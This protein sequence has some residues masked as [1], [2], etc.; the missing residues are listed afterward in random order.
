[1][2]TLRTRRPGEFCWINMLTPEPEQARGFFGS[3]LG[4]TYSDMPGMGHLIQ[5]GG[6]P[7]GGLFDLN[8]PNTPPGTPAHIGVMVKVESAD[9]I[10]A[11]VTALGGTARA[12]FDIGASGRMAVC[13]DP[14][15]APF[16]IWEP[17]KNAGT[18]V[19]GTL[20]GAP[21][22]FETMTTDAA[23]AATFYDQLFGWTSSSAPMPWGVPYTTF[24]LGSEAVAGMM[25]IMPGMGAMPAHWAVYVTVADT[26][27]CAREAVA[28]G[29]T[30]FLPAQEIPGTGRFC[31]I[32][33]PQGVAFSVI[34][35]A[36]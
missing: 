13:H 26:D 27:V 32:R 5:V 11:K 18:D 29:A 4:W 30:V 1:M 25:P 2:S 28:L 21:C 19:D 12:P 35:H 23:R 14:N 15:G 7:I 16:D 17:R 9:A 33:S 34:A 24:K 8:G 31:G 22:W 3:L 10:A 36:R 20:H 6:R